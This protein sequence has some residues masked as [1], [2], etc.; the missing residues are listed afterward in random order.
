MSLVPLA[1]KKAEIRKETTS[2]SSAMGINIALGAAIR[3]LQQGILLRNNK[4]I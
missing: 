3:R 4:T 2:S 1:E